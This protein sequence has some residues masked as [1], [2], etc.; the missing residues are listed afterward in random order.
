VGI[1]VGCSSLAKGPAKTWRSG[2]RKPGQRP[3]R[4]A[5]ATRRERA[6]RPR[7]EREMRNRVAPHGRVMRTMTLEQATSTAH[8]DGANAL[9]RSKSIAFALFEYGVLAPKV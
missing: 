7:G 8:G 4:S 5:I 9:T 1:P 6:L 2:R 3:L